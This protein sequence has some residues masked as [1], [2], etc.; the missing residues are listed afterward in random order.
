MVRALAAIL[1]GLRTDRVVLAL[2]ATLGTKAAAQLLEALRPLNVNAIAITHA[3]ETDQLGAAVDAACK[4][5]LA[6]LYT[7]GRSRGAGLAQVQPAELAERLL[8]GQ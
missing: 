5:G 6:P 2:P 1:T 8:P 4:S 7:L 3:D